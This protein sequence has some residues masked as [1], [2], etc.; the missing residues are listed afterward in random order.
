VNWKIVHPDERRSNGF[1][2]NVEPHSRGQAC[3]FE[4]QLGHPTAIALSSCRCSKCSFLRS[5]RR[6]QKLKETQG[7]ER[8]EPLKKISDTPLLFLKFLGSK[9]AIENIVVLCFSITISL[10]FVSFSSAPP[11]SSQHFGTEGSKITRELIARVIEPENAPQPIFAPIVAPSAIAA[12]QTNSALIA[13][14]TTNNIN[15][16]P[17]PRFAPFV[18]SPQRP[19]RPT[20]L[21]VF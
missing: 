19:P 17:A 21:Q 16:N 7:Q 11:E 10:P 1:I 18:R 3:R 14:P 15:T 20:G 12:P 2:L 6:G 4:S 8:F 5:A 13:G 9:I